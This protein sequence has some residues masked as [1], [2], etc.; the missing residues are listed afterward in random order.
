MPPV[1]GP[2]GYQPALTESGSV[3]VVADRDGAAAGVLD[4]RS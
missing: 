3:A 1:H 2:S 4:R